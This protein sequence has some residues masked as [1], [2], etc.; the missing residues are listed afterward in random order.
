MILQMYHVLTIHLSP[1]SSR[2]SLPTQQNFFAR[3][4][5]LGVGEDCPATGD[6]VKC[7]YIGTLLDGES[8]TQHFPHRLLLPLPCARPEAGLSM[9]LRAQLICRAGRWP[10][11]RRRRFA[12]WSA[13]V[14][15]PGCDHD[16]AL[17]PRRTR[18]AYVATCHSPPTTNTHQ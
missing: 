10:I 9:R 7:H 14:P 17:P 16:P 12:S 8:A 13:R 2:P 6:K 11:A 5:V 18:M 3:S 1:L 4:T 15:P